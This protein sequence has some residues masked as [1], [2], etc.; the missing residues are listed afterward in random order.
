VAFEVPGTWRWRFFEHMEN[1]G[2]FE[3]ISAVVAAIA[4][5]RDMLTAK[6]QRLHKEISYVASIIPRD[7]DVYVVD[8]RLNNSGTVPITRDDYDR[9]VGFGFGQSA[10]LRDARVMEQNPHDLGVE[11]HLTSPSTVELTPVLL[12]PGEYI[13]LRVEVQGLEA[14][15]ARGHVL[16]LREIK[17]VTTQTQ[18][19]RGYL[20]GQGF[21]EA[22]RSLATHPR[23]FFARL[24]RSGNYVKPL[25]FAVVSFG[26]GVI[27]REIISAFEPEQ[28]PSLLTD[29]G[30]LFFLPLGV[31]IGA[32]GL[33]IL[34][35]LSLRLRSV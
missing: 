2:V 1:L 28:F 31:V 3:L 32:F 18:E 8:I 14:V 12:N 19:R 21:V 27:P 13:T 9:P 34:M 11:V 33:A 16:G 15:Q 20:E 5:G 6:V 22:V 24:P 30:A 7:S 35:H 23:A 29:A 4:L 26:I 25:L 10:Q 17:Q